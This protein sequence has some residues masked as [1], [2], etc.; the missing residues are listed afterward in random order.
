MSQFIETLELIIQDL[1]K[2]YKE[3][4]QLKLLKI[5]SQFQNQFLSLKRSDIEI[6]STLNRLSLKQILE[7]QKKLGLELISQPTQ[8]IKLI[9]LISGFALQKKK[10]KELLEAARS[11]KAMKRKSSTKTSKKVPA[12]SDSDYKILRKLWLTNKNLSQLESELAGINMN[13]IRAVVKPWKLKPRDRTKK[14]LI[15][16]VIEY[17]KRMK[18]LS[19]LGTY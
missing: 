16:A 12:S 15:K 3:F 17:I 9:S 7:C 10:K 4:D 5:I 1:S 18:K 14:A 8:K 19:K 2:N 11:L 6:K 13:K